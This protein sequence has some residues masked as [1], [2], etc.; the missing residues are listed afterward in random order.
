MAL[1]ELPPGRER[2]VRGRRLCVAAVV[3]APAWGKGVVV[4]AENPPPLSF[5]ELGLRGPGG[6]DAD[7]ENWSPLRRRERVRGE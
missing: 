6:G 4:G 1:S 5:P 3:A 7:G 2:G